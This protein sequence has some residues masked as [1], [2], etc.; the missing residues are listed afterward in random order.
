M[1]WTYSNLGGEIPQT[2]E[3]ATLTLMGKEDILIYFGGYYCTPDL[4]VE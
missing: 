3:R 2:R 1:E 4:E